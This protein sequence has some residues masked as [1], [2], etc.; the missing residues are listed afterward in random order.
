MRGRVGRRGDERRG[1][2]GREQRGGATRR[3]DERR[4]E[5]QKR[6]QRRAR[7]T[8][9]EEAASRAG[10]GVG[11]GRQAATLRGSS[12]CVCVCAA[13]REERT[14]NAAAQLSSARLS[15]ARA[16]SRCGPP[17]PARCLWWLWSRPRHVRMALLSISRPPIPLRAL[18]EAVS[19]SG[20]HS[21]CAAALRD[22][23]VERN[24]TTARE[25]KRRSIS[26][27]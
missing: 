22:S 19:C 12:V 18:T 16:V 2:R 5:A 7:R 8:R 13:R 21:A 27:V 15:S 24:A 9:R 11:R 4:G 23:N 25:I 6:Q 20:S 1:H 26:P 3:A 17:C 14:A 10:R